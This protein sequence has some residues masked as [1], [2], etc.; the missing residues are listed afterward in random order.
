M[1][2]CETKTHYRP[3]R[4]GTGVAVSFSLLGIL[5]ERSFLSLLSLCALIA[6]VCGGLRVVLVIV[7]YLCAASC[8]VDPPVSTIVSLLLCYRDNPRI[9]T[10]MCRIKQE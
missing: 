9:N 4:V 6:E 3:F 1:I 8:R 2:K 10:T 7:L 5:E